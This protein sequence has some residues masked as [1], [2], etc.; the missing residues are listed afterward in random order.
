MRTPSGTLPNLLVGAL[1]LLTG[2]AIALSL[3]TAPQVAQQQLKVAAMNTAGAASFV[4]VDHVTIREPR[5]TSAL[6]G[7]SSATTTQSVVYQAP[8]RVLVSSSSA[9][10]T[11]LLVIGNQRYERTGNGPWSPL[12]AVGAGGAS[13]GIQEA[14]LLLFPL[15][16]LADS[17]SVTMTGSTY[18]FVPGA[19]A[20]L[21]EDLFGTLASQLSTLRFSAFVNGEFV[22]SERVLAARGDARF[23]IDF[24]YLS[25]DKAPALEVP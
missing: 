1:T 24:A 2:G 10:G 19:K 20:A 21:V 13:T 14:Q 4:F 25:I 3:L 22:R 18:R 12:P 7:R 16:S 6:G 23:T 17:T 9:P 8:D 5:P 15:Q 11:M